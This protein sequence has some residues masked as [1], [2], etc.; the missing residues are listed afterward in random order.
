MRTPWLDMHMRMHLRLHLIHTYK[1][2][3]IGKHMCATIPYSEQVGGV[4][5]LLARLPR[6][7]R[8]S[9]RALLEYVKTNISE[10]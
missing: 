2:S 5:T 3:H 1:H 10:Y 7:S 8:Q 4:A 9:S 6:E